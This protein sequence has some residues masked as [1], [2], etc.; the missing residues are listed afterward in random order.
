MTVSDDLESELVFDRLVR[1]L[2]RI[3]TSAISAERA[4]VVMDRP[5]GLLVI[6]TVDN[7]GEVTTGQTPLRE[8][9]TAPISLIEYVVQ[10]G[11]PVVLPD[12]PADG[13]FN[14]DPYF[15]LRP[16]LSIVAVPIGRTE[17]T[18]GVMYFEKSLS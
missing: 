3:C 16:P 17:L 9:Q 15:G 18:R 12:V 7:S 14:N 1:N 2:V 4:M 5:T 13:R 6:A 10:S 8:A 11:Q